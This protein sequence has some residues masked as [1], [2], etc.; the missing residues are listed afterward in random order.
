M[1]LGAG[2]TARAE[3]IVTEVEKQSPGDR[4]GFASGDRL[5]H[6]KRGQRSGEF[7]L[8]RD[9]DRVATEEL[10][11]GAV[12]VTVIRGGRRLKVVAA[13]GFHG[14]KIRPQL[15][16]DFDARLATAVA[17]RDVAVLAT[18]AAELAGN[19]RE[20]AVWIYVERALRS[21]PNAV[22]PAFDEA[23]AAAGSEPALRSW[24]QAQ[25]GQALLTADP[26]AAKLSLEEV[27]TRMK[28]EAPDSLT[29]AQL[30]RNLGTALYYQ[31]DLDQAERAHT[32]ALEIR[33]RLAPG[34]LD[35]AGSLT[36][37]LAIAM[38]RGDFTAAA[39]WNR[40]A[41]AIRSKLAPGSSLEAGSLSN[42]GVIAHQLGDLATAEEYYRRALSI[43]RGIAPNGPEIGSFSTN[44]GILAYARGDLDGAAEWHAKALENAERTEKSPLDRAVVYETLGV[45]A[46][47]RRDLVT[48]ESWHRK[49]LEIRQRYSPKSLGVAATLNNL[50]LVALARGELD[51]AFEWEVGA[52]EINEAQAPESQEVASNLHNLSAIAVESNQLD[53]AE[54]WELEAL[55]IRL[56]RAPEGPEVANTWASLA[57]VEEKRGHFEKAA[58][59]YEES[60]SALS[61]IAP[62][63]LDAATFLSNLAMAL[64]QS[65]HAA[66]GLPHAERSVSIRRRLAPGSSLEAEAL[67]TLSSALSASGRP[68]DA[69]ER[70]EEARAALERQQLRL[71]G[72]PET[73]SVFRLKF[74]PLY[75]LLIEL[76][77]DSGCTEDAAEVF[78]S[79]RA[80]ALL[81]L[82]AERSLLSAEVPRELERDRALANAEAD[83]IIDAVGGAKGDE[84]VRRLMDELRAVRERQ[85]E[86][87]RRVIEASPRLAALRYPEPLRAAEMRRLLP[88]GTLALAWVLD[89][90]RSTLL[91]ISREGI[92]AYRLDADAEEIQKG[93]ETLRK[94]I[95]RSSTRKDVRDRL[96]SDL[97][98]KLFGGAARSLESAGRL[99]IFPDGPLWMLPFAMLPDPL[100]PDRLLVEDHTFVIAHSA[101]VLAELMRERRPRS[102][103]LVAFGDPVYPESGVAL[104]RGP[105]QLRALP[106]TRSEVE[107]I[108]A[109]YGGD[110]AVHLGSDANV[111]AV[112][113]IGS[114]GLAPAILH[115]AA[116]AVVDELRPL[117]S[118]VVLSAGGA[119][120]DAAHNGLLE[121]RELFEGIHLD[122][123]LVVLSACETALGREEAGEGISGLTRGFQYAGARSVLASLW[124]V[125]DESTGAL[126]KKFYEGL[127]AGLAKDDALRRAQLALLRAPIEVPRNGAT[128]SIDASQP[129]QWAGFELFGDWE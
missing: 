61:R 8:P 1:A 60:L 44:L 16:G 54:E 23:L 20:S 102:S 108:A 88:A 43:M 29:E 13:V 21:G 42:A 82:L 12:D 40:K 25:R 97:S 121:A 114:A 6:W 34:G 68:F 83:K 56:R 91:A 93:V 65:G 9:F 124:T 77:V 69:I 49:V 90:Q 115:F 120:G 72:A 94:A 105:A 31:G 122:C 30:L 92:T 2:F 48:A 89:A 110:A 39:E 80:R 103:T 70:L 10:P 66:A 126:M 119:S 26:A 27:L 35:V 79:A 117:A 33:Q 125:S 127:H 96:A 84:E 86:I 18:L 14:L 116:H 45:V 58:W 87:R 36:A 129:F 128:T 118:A 106:G 85:V 47:E 59:L 104:E 32:R 81:A 22:G 5:S 71:G 99:V 111:D 50:A 113:A 19:D 55:T 46:L 123:D 63:G 52:L 3:V 17:S 112:R 37:L 51:L 24:V 4:A 95:E 76:L 15:T 67:W 75:R 38:G 41:L 57:N 109:L 64:T 98:R 74:L 73:L 11:R 28:E 53:L 107:S 7:V 101:T 100:H 62:S 78:E